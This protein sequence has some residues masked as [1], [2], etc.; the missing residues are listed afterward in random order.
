MHPDPHRDAAPWSCRRP[1]ARQRAVRRVVAV[2]LASLLAP[3][4]AACA[5]GD[6]DRTATGLYRVM[7]STRNPAV[8]Q[9]EHG[10]EFGIVPATRAM[11]HAPQALLVME[12]RLGGAVEQRIVLPNATSVRGDNVLHVRAQ[13]ET[14]AR[15]G[16]FNFNDIAVRFGGLPAP[17]ER[18]NPGSLL[19]GSDALAAMSMRA[20][21]WASTRSAC[22]SCA[23]SAPARGPCRAGPSPST[24]S[25][26]TASSAR[27]SRPWPR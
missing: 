20:R 11:V 16:E 8:E 10:A 14:T 1:A 15:S 6:G 27:W 24:S 12:R 13:T 25:C 3:I 19:S 26:A 7:N 18:A 17:F 2:V 23:A 22:W 21:T 9:L 4:L 5:P